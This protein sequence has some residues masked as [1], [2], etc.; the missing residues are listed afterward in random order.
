MKAQTA[1]RSA[2][3]I[4]F[5]GLLLAI[6]SPITSGQ[7]TSPSQSKKIIVTVTD[8]DQ[9]A[10]TDLKAEDFKLYVDGQPQQIS[11]VTTSDASTC[12]GLVVDTSGSMRGKH[13]NVT[14]ALLN[15]VSAVNAQGQTFVVN[16][17]DKGYL[18][19]DLTTDLN[20]V[21][22]GLER[23]DPRGG[24]ALYDAIY[25]ASRHATK[26]KQCEQRTLVVLTDGQD[27]ES[28]M[29]L[30]DLIREVQMSDTS[31]IYAIVL[32]DEHSSERARRAMEAIAKQIGGKAFFSGNLNKDVRDVT[33]AIR[34]QYIINYNAED[35]H[36]GTYHFV[37][38]VAQSGHHSALMVSG[39][40]GYYSPALKP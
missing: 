2:W 5:A 11:S 39:Q 6:C 24:T 30:E 17:N 33:Q 8:A 22:R 16:F 14:K 20:L 40:P 31:A 37:K 19:Q 28:Q 29:N 4:I 34:S 12:L 38:V 15:L 1:S 27:N 18:D 23:G 32:P 13:G 7:Q 25:A 36:D 9:K 10:V 26:A 3:T 35:P 21:R